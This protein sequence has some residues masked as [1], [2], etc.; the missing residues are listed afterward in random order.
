METAGWSAMHPRTRGKN[1]DVATDPGRGRAGACC[2]NAAE[3]GGLLRKP[4][5]RIIS[6]WYS[7]QVYPADSLIA[8][9]GCEGGHDCFS[10]SAEC[11]IRKKDRWCVE[12][13]C[14]NPFPCEILPHLDK[15]REQVG[16]TCEF[17]NHDLAYHRAGDGE[18]D[19]MLQALQR[20]MRVHMRAGH[21][22]PGYR[23]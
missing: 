9:A 16:D 5:R 11:G 15:I 23:G 10:C 13:P 4:Q 3:R 6:I 19:P 7:G 8:T 18:P 22:S 2:R 14:G 21:E 12:A 1:C 17:L 20:A